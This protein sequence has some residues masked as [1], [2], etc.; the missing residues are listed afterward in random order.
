MDFQKIAKI[1]TEKKNFVKFI[2]NIDNWYYYE[3]DYDTILKKDDEQT[4]Y[5]I[6][7][8]ISFIDVINDRLIYKMTNQYYNGSELNVTLDIKY[9]YHKIIKEIEE[10]EIC[11]SISESIL[12]LCPFIIIKDIKISFS[13]ESAK[14]ELQLDTSEIEQK[15]HELL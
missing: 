3:Y 1:I 10:N 11:E 4:K 12:K 9:N 14:M 6:K 8:K 5:F 15:I 2:K 13:L 7:K